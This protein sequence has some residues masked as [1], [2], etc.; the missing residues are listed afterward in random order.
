[1]VIKLKEIREKIDKV[2]VEIVALLKRRFELALMTKKLKT[3]VTDPEREAGILERV[4]K[5]AEVLGL[6]PPEF[7]EKIFNSTI[8]ESKHLQG[9]DFLLGGFQGEYGAYSEIASLEYNSS[10]VPIAFEDFLDIFQNVEHGYLDLGVVPVEN[11]I[12]GAITQVNEL[13]IDT[14]LKI[15]GEVKLPIR[16]C[17]L[18]LPGVDHKDIKTVY[19][20]PQAISQCRSFIE[21]NKLEGRPYYDTAGAAKMLSSSMPATSA[22]IASLRCAQI[23][24][25]EVIKEGIEDHKENYTRFVVISKKENGPATKSL[26]KTSIIFSLP[27]RAGTLFE[28]L[29]LFADAGMNLTRIE[30]MPRRDLPGSY[31]FFLDFTGNSHDEKAANILAEIEKVSTKYN[32]LGCYKGA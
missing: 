3:S 2:D 12:G 20:H 31:Y 7:I 17:L 18:A 29:K 1:M 9:K 22:V 30:S 8:T 13:L 28:V 14:E 5:R 32:F 6:I 19:S 11:T 16:H 21:R 27:D 26:N 10:L 4:K 25:L 15:V 24:G 23:Y